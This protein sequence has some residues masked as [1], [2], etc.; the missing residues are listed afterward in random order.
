MFTETAN[1]YDDI[2]A[3]LDYEKSAANLRALIEAR[4]DGRT[5]LDIACGSGKHLV[6]FR[7]AG[8]EVEGLDLDPVILELAKNRIDAPLH[9][10][11][12]CDFDLGKT[13]DVITNNFSSI[14]Y[15]QTKQRLRSAIACVDRHLNP[16]GVALIEPWFTREKYVPGHIHM[17][18]VDLPDLKIAR[19]NR[20]DVEGDLSVID[21][22]YVIVTPGEGARFVRECHKLAM[23]EVEEFADAAGGMKHEYIENDDFKR[24]LH[25]FTK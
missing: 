24:G 1:Y 19:G 8:Y 17:T 2:Y 4:T 25:V 7:E 5:L 9:V 15:A 13:F 20:G 6:C 10:G 3:G 12:M 22:H 23:F 21:F 14:G 18:T 16:G 11:D